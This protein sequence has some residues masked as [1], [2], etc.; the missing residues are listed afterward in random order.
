MCRPG[1]N[2]FR[3]LCFSIF[4]SKFPVKKVEISGKKMK[5]HLGNVDY[6]RGMYAILC[7]IWRCER[8]ESALA[9][10]TLIVVTP[11]KHHSFLYNE[12][13]L[14]FIFYSLFLI[15]WF[16]L[17]YSSSL[18]H[19]FSVVCISKAVYSDK[20]IKRWIWQ[21]VACKYSFSQSAYLF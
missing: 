11:G 1:R 21:Q 9:E 19:F 10:L 7:G 3:P 20:K 14:F 17:F 4:S 2:L 15:I 13:A 5:N 6:C 18:W 12:S 16:W 8:D